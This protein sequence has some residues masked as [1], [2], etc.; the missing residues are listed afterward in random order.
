MP[1]AD[2]QGT[3]IYYEVHGDGPPLVMLSGLFGNVALLHE[4]GYIRALKEEYQVIA[5]DY[6]G[7]GRSGLLHDSDQYSLRLFAE[8]AIAVLDQLQIERC[9]I[10]GHSL[11]GW[12]LF[13]SAE[14][15]PRGGGRGD[16]KGGQKG[17]QTPK[18][19]RLAAFLSPGT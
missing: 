9:H 2:N 8:D 1:Y 6:R 7:V 10:Y 19:D 16:R 14:P 4:F 12:T 13:G 3:K 15:P 17:L 5:I 18:N 11:G